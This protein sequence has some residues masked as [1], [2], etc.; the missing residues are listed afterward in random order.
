[1]EVNHGHIILFVL[2]IAKKKN[3]EANYQTPVQPHVPEANCPFL[4]SMKERDRND[5]Q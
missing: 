5:R 3:P 2:Y 4:H 1:M